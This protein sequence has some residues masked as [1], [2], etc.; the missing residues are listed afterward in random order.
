MADAIKL[1]WPDGKQTWDLP[2]LFEDAT[3]LILDKPSGLP[4]ISDA[5]APAEANLLRLLHEELPPAAPGPMRGRSTF[6]APPT[7]SIRTRAA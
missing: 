1:S 4:A 7:N 5:I 3:L 6:F 2:V